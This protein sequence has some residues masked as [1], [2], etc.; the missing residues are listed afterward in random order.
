VETD[1]DRF[2]RHSRS[3]RPEDWRCALELVRGRPFEG[4][5]A[6]DWALLEGITAAIEAV[7]VDLSCRYAEICL[8]SGDA[9]GAEWAARQG[10]KV[11]AYDE[12]LYRILMRAADVAGNPAGVESTMAELVHLVSD[13]VEPFDAVH[14]ETL[15]LYRMLSRRQLVSRSR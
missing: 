5:R 6:P 1:W 15:D 11:S 4:L 14:P 3:A 9:A 7:V 8:S 2:V 12:R 10:L 13:D